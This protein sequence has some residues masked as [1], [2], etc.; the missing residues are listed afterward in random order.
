MADVVTVQLRFGVTT[1]L[2]LYQDTLSF[3]EVE[4][5]KRD[6]IAVEAA[7]QTLADT[8]VQ[9]RSAQI[10]EEQA[11]KTEEG[12]QAKIAEIDA[13]IA[14]LTA[15]KDALAVAAVAIEVTP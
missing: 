3:T 2:G 11:L 6:S 1:S 13:Q 10:A 15:A 5:A 12:K 9:F 8:W 14:D 4:W 7:K